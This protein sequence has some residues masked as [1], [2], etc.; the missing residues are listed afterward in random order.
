MT[1]MQTDRSPFPFALQTMVMAA[2][3]LV[4][5]TLGS[6]F[7]QSNGDLLNDLG[8]GG[9]FIPDS[10]GLK[11][12]TI[13]YW[14]ASP[15]ERDWGGF[16]GV[17][18]VINIYWVGVVA[19]V[20]GVAV[21]NFLFLLVAAWFFVAS[22]RA[23]TSSNSSLVL[24]SVFVAVFCNFYLVEVLLFPNKEISLIAL[25]NG[26]IYALVVRRNVW[27]AL[28]IAGLV[29]FVRDGYALILVVAVFFVRFTWSRPPH[30]NVLLLIAAVTLFSLLPI[31]QFRELN[32]V[33]SRN[34]G[35]G[36]TLH[37]PIDSITSF[38]PL[39]FLLKMVGNATNL[40]TRPQLFDGF[41]RL[42]LSGLG[43]WQLGVLIVG[44]S[45][46]ALINLR[47]V[48]R[49]HRDI[50]TVIAILLI[51]VSVSSFVQPRYM[52]PAIFWLAYGTLTSR[53]CAILSVVAGVMAPAF[54]Y[55]IGYLPP[56][57]YG[58]DDV[59]WHW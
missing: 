42:Y 19:G 37:S 31:E 9:F 33:I 45:A 25:T 53:R 11:Q 29:F 23:L 44:G 36:S 26:F 54:F 59:N 8:L 1:C 12:N 24:L 51:G 22:S 30:Y 5:V 13:D 7:I 32:Y 50:A 14:G 38:G 41:G 28:A 16:R 46:W 35:F 18:G 57:P 55:L 15:D 47:S 6:L 17:L 10:V 39:K 20:V 40:S 4:C 52:M 58:I 34:V 49:I 2:A 43:F 3:V 27:G 56:A 48:S 21:V